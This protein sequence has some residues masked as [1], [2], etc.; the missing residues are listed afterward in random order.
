MKN[1]INIL[2]FAC[3]A[4][5]YSCKPSDK[6]KESETPDKK[7]APVLRENTA[8]KVPL[9]QAAQNTYRYDSLCKK[10]FNDDV[11]IR[12]Y[13]IHAADLLDVL[14]LDSSYLEYCRY[15]HSRVYLG[16]D[17]D[18]KFKLYFTPVVAA[19]LS[20]DPPVAGRDTIMGDPTAG[21]DGLFVFDLNAPCPR[22]C[23]ENSQLYRQQ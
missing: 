1:S 6:P 18:Y 22:T 23:D 10:V 16:L 2:V 21:P 3:L 20:Y 7:P 11:P 4:L 12:A 8:V 5:V 15:K 19:D 13:T 17:N 14:G 9:L